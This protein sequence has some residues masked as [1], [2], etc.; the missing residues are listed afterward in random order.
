MPRRARFVLPHYPH[1]I[2]QKGN[3]AQHTF[4]D[5]DDFARYR[6]LVH[7]YSHEREVAIQTY[8]LM[9]NH[10]HLLSV[11][12]G[13]TALAEMMR[14]V[15]CRYT[16][17]FNKKYGR[18]GRLWESRFRSSVVD[19]DEYL[20]WVSLYIEWNPVRAKL[21]TRPEEWRYSSARHHALGE[22]DPLVAEALF[23]ALDME[24]YRKLL[25][26]GPPEERVNEIR[27]STHANRP[28][29]GSDFL[30]RLKASF[31]IS[32]RSKRGRPRKIV[33]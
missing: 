30:T 26:E 19:T 17:Y 8:C 31:G 10:V 24:E 23:D 32:A 21:V 2:V 13:D 4:L 14:S 25:N 3:N 20:W 1:H 6:Q 29:G 11:P 7:D 27:K 22:K 15:A 12:E 9:G 33:T 18:K 5:G 16:Q 28:I